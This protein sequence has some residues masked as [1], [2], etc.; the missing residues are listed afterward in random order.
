MKTTGYPIS[1]VILILF[2]N[3]A[4]NAQPMHGRMGF[5]SNR[6]EPGTI[7]VTT[8]FRGKLF[9][10]DRPLKKMTVYHQVKISGIDTGVHTLSFIADTVEIRHE[11]RIKP[12]ST[13]YYIIRPDSAVLNSAEPGKVLKGPR[14]KFHVSYVPRTKGLCGLVKI[15]ISS[16]IAGA[17]SPFYGQIIAGW[18][19]SPRFSLG[20]GIG[21][22]KNFSKFQYYYKTYSVIG[23]PTSHT[24]IVS[25]DFSVPYLPVFADIRLVLSKRKVSP[26]FAANIGC[27]IPLRQQIDGTFSG[28]SDMDNTFHV[29][30]IYPGFYFGINPGVKSFFYGRYYLDF[31]FGWDICVNQFHGKLPDGNSSKW[32]STSGFHVNIGFGF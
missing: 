17:N 3:F 1:I 30:G 8:E 19:F 22:V 14:L 15:G 21:Y 2:T 27:S 25:S 20:G 16:T 26:Y 24:S 11:F 23:L 31:L 7:I 9:I 10:D 32:K 18:Q 28:G 13:G 29:S 5:Q 12:G 6:P 4:V